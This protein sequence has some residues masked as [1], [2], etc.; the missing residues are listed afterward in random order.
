MS[1]SLVYYSNTFADWVTTTN[2]VVNKVNYFDTGD[3]IKSSGTSIINVPSAFT[4]TL[5][6][7]GRTTYTS[8]VS[9]A[10]GNVQ[11]SNTANV[12][13]SVNTFFNREL[14]SNNV[15]KLNN[16]YANGNVWF[17]NSSVISI[18][19]NSLIANLN[20]ELLG[21]RNS[22]YYIELSNT[23]T[24]QAQAAYSQANTG[25]TQAQA[26]FNQANSAYNQANSFSTVIAQAAFTQANTGVTQAQ[27]AFSRA[28]S[29][30]SQANTANTNAANASFLS[31]GTVATA[32]LGSGTANSTTYLRGDNSWATV[33][34]GG[35]TLSDNLDTTTPLYIGLSAS[36]SGAWTSAIV[37]TTKLYFTPNTGTL[38]AT[39]FNSL[40]D[41]TKKTNI[42][43]ISNSIDLIKQIDGVEFNW[44]DNDKK[45]A[46]V[47]AQE[48]ELILPHLVTEE[49]GTK[50]VNYSG[51]T[52]Y[53][54]ECVKELSDKIENLEKK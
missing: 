11:F 30:Y 7:S 19:N 54:I 28:N 41:I 38:S 52:A 53:L 42:N 8:N 13:F 43:K 3:F 20:S 6:I 36:S 18:S 16:V 24:T 44:L 26:A 21:G 45:S 14:T 29:A 25:T 15:V 47:I 40:S 50:S 35:A 31:T 34:G 51:L 49:N 27:A 39:I 48:L 12:M 2:L 4:S 32:R 46:G 10:A 33:A 37:S 9:F 5:D 22:S 17:G 1:I 23:G